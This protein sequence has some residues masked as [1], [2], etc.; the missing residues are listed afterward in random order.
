MANYR[1]QE[2]YQ[3]TGKKTMNAAITQ[4]TID[5]NLQALADL[6]DVLQ[7][8]ALSTDKNDCNNAL[9]ICQLIC[10]LSV[11]ISAALCDR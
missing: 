4:S 7:E 8:L 1:T 5:T 6:V 3:R 10:D 2:S 11:E 9:N